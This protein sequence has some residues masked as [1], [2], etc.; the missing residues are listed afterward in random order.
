MCNNDRRKGLV[1]IVPQKVTYIISHVLRKCTDLCRV[2]YKYPWDQMAALR[3]DMNIVGNWVLDFQN[4]LQR[5]PIILVKHFS[6]ANTITDDK[7]W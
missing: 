5:H 2:S 7:A 6:G 3:R 1:A 4:A